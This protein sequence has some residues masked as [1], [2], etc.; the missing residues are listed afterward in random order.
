MPTRS[1][2]LQQSDGSLLI[3]PRALLHPETNI[4]DKSFSADMPI[5]EWQDWMRWDGAAIESDQSPLGRKDSFE[6]TLS[7]YDAADIETAPFSA[8]STDTQFSFDDAPF[9]IETD[10]STDPS[11]FLTT[12]QIP[13]DLRRPARG[14][15]TLTA[16][17]QQRLR[18]I[19][20]PHRMLSQIK[21]SSQSSSPT[22]TNSSQSPSPF[23]EPESRTRKNKK[24]KSSV[25]DEELPNELCQSRKRGHNA[26]EKRYRTNLNDKINFLRQGIPPLWRR[27][28]TDSKSGDEAEDSD[29][30]TTDKKR[31]QQK[32]GKAAILTRALEYI[33]H[34]EST[35][36]RFGDEVAVLKTRVGAFERLAMS[37]SIVMNSAPVTS[38][39]LTPKTE[40]LESIQADF[41][42]IKHKSVSSRRNSKKV[43]GK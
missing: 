21:L 17:E 5:E 30:E 38:G 24:R 23:P 6:S 4:F 14:Y 13:M 29:Q 16:A 8:C 19:A 41:K 11:Q 18:D 43:V 31:G 42:Q 3:T 10:E 33:Q 15:S 39:L 35:T 25:E 22:A 34:L 2:Y 9:E 20:M 1:L 7:M 26:I 27:S 28:S 12:S 32:Y 40:T 37:G 36:Q